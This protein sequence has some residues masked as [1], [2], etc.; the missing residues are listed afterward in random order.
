MRLPFLPWHCA[1][2]AAAEPSKGHCE[3]RWWLERRGRHAGPSPPSRRAKGTLVPVGGPHPLTGDGLPGSWASPGLTLSFSGTLP[4]V[5]PNFQ[6]M[7][8]P[9]VLGYT[10]WGR[11]RI[12]ALWA[13]RPGRDRMDGQMPEGR[14]EG[15]G[16]RE[17]LEGHRNCLHLIC[18]KTKKDN[19]SVGCVKPPLR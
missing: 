8:V 14:G 4:R 12:W 18:P 7:T 13:P 16:R 15:Q 2:D 19:S 10:L 1:Q 6:G 17:E 11:E 9:P 5:T 3:R